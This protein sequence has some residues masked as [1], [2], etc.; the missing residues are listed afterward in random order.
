M[1]GKRSEVRY[2]MLFRKD[3]AIPMNDGLVLR[4]NVFRPRA[5]GR[6][7][8]VMAQGVYGKDTH[9]ADGFA[10]QY[11]QLVRTFPGFATK[12]LERALCPLGDGRPGTL[13]TGRLRGN[14][15]GCT[16]YRQ[17]AGLS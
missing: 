15:G 12:G 8:V 3:V 14:S 4:A 11:E 17:L 9:F 13:G 2:E 5:A 16:G 10:V 7:P 6:F 1:T